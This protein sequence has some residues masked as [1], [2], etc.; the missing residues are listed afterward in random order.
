MAQPDDN[1]IDSIPVDPQN[2]KKKC[3]TYLQRVSSNWRTQRNVTYFNNSFWSYIKDWIV[4]I[5]LPT[6]ILVGFG[7]DTN[8]FLYLK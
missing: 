8:M 4:Y 1:D 6:F 2:F 7:I 3:N 5:S